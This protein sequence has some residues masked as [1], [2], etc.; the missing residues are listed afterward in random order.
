MSNI[1]LI[2]AP[3]DEGQRRAGCV[4]GPAAYRV[5]GISAAIRDLGH[6]VQDWGDLALP[7]LGEATCANP[8]VHSLPQ[9]LGWTEVLTDK[10]DDALSAG[11]LP[12][13]LGA[14]IPWR[15]ARSRGRRL[16]RSGKGGPCSCCGWT[17]IPIS[18]RP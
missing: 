8:A 6:G 7:P 1:I 2:G 14:I 18:T 17:R 16:S 9:V 12:V 13:I 10:V 15:W 5:A 4:M 11:G 3:I